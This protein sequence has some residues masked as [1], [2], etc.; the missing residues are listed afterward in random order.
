MDQAQSQHLS[1]PG[2]GSH[3]KAFLGIFLLMQR[4]GESRALRAPGK[5]TAGKGVLLREW[6]QRGLG[7]GR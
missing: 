2:H 5:H 6:L 1:I 3:L 4:G 7:E